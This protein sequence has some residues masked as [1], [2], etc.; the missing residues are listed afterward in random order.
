MKLFIRIILK[1]FLILTISIG[2]ET[3]EETLEDADA[4]N[5]QGNAY[6]EKGWK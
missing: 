3:T 2:C 1:M 4:Y 6:Y 5:N